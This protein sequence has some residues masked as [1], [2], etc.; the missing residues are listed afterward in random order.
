MIAR[1]D[2]RPVRAARASTGVSQG[3]GCVAPTRVRRGV[4]LVEILVSGVVIGVGLAGVVGSATAVETQMGGGARETVAAA[5][6]QAR[7]DSLASLSCAQLTGGLSGY[8]TT[9]GVTE[10]WRVVDGRNTKTLT[11]TLT[12]PRRTARPVYTTV[13]PCRD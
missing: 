4:T 5:L 9:R 10:N 3:A 11:V 6:A 12:L 8:S 7:L 1:N 2:G 13:I